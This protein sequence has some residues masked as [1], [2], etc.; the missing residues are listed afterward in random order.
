MLW[1]LELSPV[2][3]STAQRDRTVFFAHG[4]VPCA[5][6][7]CIRAY[8]RACECIQKNACACV[9]DNDNDNVN[10]YDNDIVN[11]NDNDND[12]EQLL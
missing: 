5:F 3:F 8:A 12:N 4:T 2:W 6:Y 10:E 7:K 9:N 1:H 11:D